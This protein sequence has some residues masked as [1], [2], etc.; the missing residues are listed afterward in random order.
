MRR[1][2]IW[3]LVAIPLLAEGQTQMH[4]PSMMRVLTHREQVPLVRSW[5]EKRF[6]VLLPELMRRE[7]IDMWIIVTREYNSD[8]VF[9]SMAPLTTYSSRR[10]TI[11]VFFDRGGAEGVER[12]SIGRFDYQGL[13]EVHQTPNHEQWAGLREV[14]E[15]RD[16]KLIGVNKSELWNHADGLTANEEDNLL[17]A[18]GAQYASRVRSAEMLAV[19]WL[20]TKIPEQ[21]DAYRHVMQVAHLVIRE[22]FSNEVI[23]PG[24]TT[25]EDVRW[26]MRQ[27]VVEMGLGKWFHPSVSIQ[28]KGGTPEEGE[29][30]HSV[31]QRGDLLHCDFGIVYLGLSTDTQHNA[32]VLELG[33]T[34]PPEGLR[35]GQRAA[36]RL[37]DIVMEKARPGVSGN[38]ALAE[39]LVEARSEGLVP[40]IYCHPIG[41][42][43]H[44][45]GP[46]IGMTDYQEGVP[47]RGEREL[48]ANTWYSIELNVRHQVPEWGGQEVRF[49]LE[50]DAAQCSTI[51]ARKA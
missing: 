25:T 21:L 48:R 47:G 9:R 1:S 51:L 4:V 28:R 49:A 29:P 39:A 27:R 24:K 31:I 30:G 36:N 33:E 10:R 20:E 34:E 6:D 7:G 18:L 14:V 37:Q 35:A 41:Y 32:Y 46:P 43:G 23:I 8:P 38:V 22:A 15:A 40:T 44:G 12:L 42:H 17:E 19:S 3:I 50:E 11:L 5:I 16:P 26:W 45:A 2:L 13:F